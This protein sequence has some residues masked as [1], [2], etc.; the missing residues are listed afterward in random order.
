MMTVKLIDTELKLYPKAQAVDFYKLFYQ[1]VF[2]PAHIL[3]NKQKAYEFFLK[4][5]EYSAENKQIQDIS[6]MQNDFIRVGLGLVNDRERFF[7]IFLKSA[8]I[9]NVISFEEWLE[10]WKEVKISL[11][12][13]NIEN[14]DS[15]LKQ[16]DKAVTS[17]K[18]VFSHSD[19]YKRLYNPHY[20]VVSKKLWE[21]L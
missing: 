17:G 3:K 1:A 21:N 7:E 20:R 19:I 5:I 13:Y 2:G 18:T 6:F 8:E 4:E 16:I 9:K 12:R 11:K 15:D 14:L 10:I